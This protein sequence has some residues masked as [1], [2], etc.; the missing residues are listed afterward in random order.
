MIGWLDNAGTF[1]K[2]APLLAKGRRLSIL[3]G[4]SS[5]Q[6]PRKTTKLFTCLG[7]PSQLGHTIVTKFYFI[8][9]MVSSK[10]SY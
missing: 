6:I 3:I 5:M 8:K 7:G 4:A 10:S 2:L 1:D 9:L